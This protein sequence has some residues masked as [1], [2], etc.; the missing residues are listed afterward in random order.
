MQY[1]R[2]TTGF[3]ISL[4]RS[5]FQAGASTTGASLESSG[6]SSGLSLT[7]EH[8][9]GP[10]RWTE[11]LL[12]SRLSGSSTPATNLV[13]GIS[14]PLNPHLRLTESVNESA[15]HLSFAHGGEL[16]TGTSSFRVDHQL[17]YLASDPV[18][19]FQQALV[20][21]AEMRVFRRLSVLGSS[22]VDPLGKTRYTLSLGTVFA[23]GGAALPEARLTRL[24]LGGNVL[25][26]MVVDTSGAPV[27]GAA[28]LIGT[29]HLYTDSAGTFLLR[30]KHTGVQGLTVLC[31]EFLTG[32]DY[33][34]VQAPAS[35]TLSPE[36]NAPVLRIV[37]DRRAAEKS[38]SRSTPAEAPASAS[39]EKHS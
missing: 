15:G 13:S 30:G 3:G 18:H 4:L 23:R 17:L 37:V 11:A 12:A 31:D 21:S 36:A 25:R 7:F 29:E 2:H 24:S 27:S 20:F 38:S 22:Y 26:G 39:R 8:S 14:I 32:G 19:P 35:V 1:Q 28:L 5:S 16:V 10:V 33:L 9:F 6:S 34:V